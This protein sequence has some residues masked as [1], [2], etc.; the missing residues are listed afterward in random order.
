MLKN[1]INTL[2]NVSGL[3]I[4]IACALLILVYIKNELAFDKFH[5]DASRIFQVTLN[6][7]FNGQEF[8]GGNIGSPVGAALFHDVPEIESYTRFYKPN[9]AVVRYEPANSEAKFFTETGI[10]A[11]DS[12]FLQLFDFPM[13]AGNS[14]EALNNPGSLVITESMARK[15]F[16]TN[17]ALGKTVLLNENRIPYKV[18]AILKDVPSQSSLQFDMLMP[19]HD[20]PVVKRFSWSWIWRL[21]VCYV[22][23]KSHVNTDPESIKSLESKFPAIVKTYAA[24]A[25]KRIGKPFDE[26][27]KNGGK[28][29]LH[30]FPLTN[31]HLY[32]SSIE[33]PWLSH[34]SSIK[35]VYIFGT[36]AV[37]IVLLACVN[38]MNL[39]TARASKRAKEIGIRKVVGSSRKQLIRQLLS[40]TFLLSVIAAVIAVGLITLLIGP[41]SV[42]TGQTMN[43]SAGLYLQLFAGIIILIIFISLVAGIYPAFYLTSFEPVEVLKGSGINKSGK[44]THL[45]RNGLVVFQFTISTIIIVCTMVVFKQLR[46]FRNSN[47]G[48]DKENVLIISNSSRL[49]KSEETFRRSIMEE[50]GVLSASITSSIPTGGTFGDGY[51]PEPDGN[52]HLTSDIDLYSFMADESFIPTLR[53]QVL[54]GRNFSRQ[55]NDSASVI[56]NEEA[57]AQIGWKD[58]IGK[59][60]KYPGNNDQRF[61]VVG[62]VKNFNVESMH[63]AIIPFALFNPSSKTYDLGATHMVAKIKPKDLVKTINNLESKWKS[64]SVAEPFDYKFLDAEFDAKYRSEQRLGK[65][66]TIFT[67]LSIFIAC[68]GLFGLC[69]FMAE[70][71]MKELGVRKVLGASVFA[72]VNLLTKDFVKLTVIAVIIASPIAWYAMHAWLQ[73]F[74]Y[75][76]EIGWVVFFIAGLATIGITVCT[77]SFQAIKAASAN[78][79]K[80]LRTE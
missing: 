46:F 77:V 26:F 54:K 73:D 68:L 44:A 48:F 62:V 28:W 21:T 12:N 66:F 31:I 19:I 42:I 3:S 6:G 29:D 37:F 16:G 33:M 47:M 55:F 22:K 7:N 20:I 57:V 65:L 14:A 9:D 51:Q 63:T 74:A 71:R 58:P 56:L 70:R 50:P 61:Q 18:T 4:G 41:F 15:Y 69:S 13:L 39:S 36:I 35:Y 67:C 43:D 1:K 38:F 52:E 59:W 75:R 49:G 8:W 72:L 2:I 64:F 17:N 80:S 45:I 40:E 11:V 60:I 79:I 25:F 5:K 27:L 32:S 30:L 76:I 53:I 10:L 23:L 78:P 34:I 24:S